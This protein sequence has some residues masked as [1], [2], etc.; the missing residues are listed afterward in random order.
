VEPFLS[1]T[2]SA[3]NRRQI[4]ELL[5]SVWDVMVSDISVSRDLAPAQINQ[6]ADTLGGRTTAMAVGSGLLDG[7]LHRDQYEDLLRSELGLD[8]DSR[9]HYVAFADYARSVKARDLSKSADKIA[10]IYAQGPIF[11]GEGGKDYIGQGLI[12]DALQRAAKADDVKAI[13]FRV[14]SPGGSA[15][16]SEIIWREMQLAKEKK[17]LVVSFGNVAA[18]GGYYIGVAGDKIFADPTTITGSI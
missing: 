18:S 3:E 16:V 9:P 11:Y 4:K 8:P 7:V 14:D 12:V 6:I 2:M 1:D 17:P 10:L 13:V 5:T 15:Q